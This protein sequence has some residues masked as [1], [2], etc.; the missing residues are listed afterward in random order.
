RQIAEGYGKSLAELAIAWVLRHKTVTAA[1][2]GARKPEQIAKNIGGGGW[3][4]SASDLENIDGLFAEIF[5]EK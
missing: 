1:I 2:A 3:Q 5:G 4:I